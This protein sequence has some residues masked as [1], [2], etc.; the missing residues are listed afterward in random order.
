MSK[1]IY[2]AIKMK[3]FLLLVFY[4]M[5]FLLPNYLLAVENSSAPNTDE[6]VKSIVEKYKKAEGGLLD[7]NNTEENKMFIQKTIQNAKNKAQNATD[8]KEMFAQ[9]ALIA[10]TLGNQAVASQL[11]EYVQNFSFYTKKIPTIFYFY[12]ESMDSVAL[13]RFYT[14][15][16]K[17]NERFGKDGLKLMTVYRGFPVGCSK[18]DIYSNERQRCEHKYV[19][20]CPVGY[21]LDGDTCYAPKRF[22]NFNKRY[23]KNSIQNG[24]FKIHP[25][26][27]RFYK[28]E[29]VPAFAF[30][31]CPQDFSFNQCEKHLLVKGDISIT[32]ALKVF[33]EENK[34]LFVYYDFLSAIK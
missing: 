24:I 15:A 23:D 22:Q 11:D 1:Y 28:L 3:K 21:E 18:G 4:L 34:E 27:Y 32:E 13:E 19:G 26:M 31:Y 12:S 17:L 29:N 2:G 30:A 9:N 25:L 33:S 8:L 6:I 16:K 20:K 10:K 5:S 7:G 14:K